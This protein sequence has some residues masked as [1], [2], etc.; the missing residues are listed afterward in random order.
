LPICWSEMFINFVGQEP[1]SLPD[2]P[3]KIGEET[4]KRI[5]AELNET[6][7][8]LKKLLSEINGIF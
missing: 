6:L 7:R 5:A 8:G 3:I 2:I 1:L 4:Q